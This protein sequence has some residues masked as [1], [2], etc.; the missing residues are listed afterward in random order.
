MKGIRC[1][2]ARSNRVMTA[3]LWAAARLGRWQ[4]PRRAE[5][6]RD[7]TRTKPR[8]R[9]PTGRAVP[10]GGSARAT[11]YGLRGSW[12]ERRMR[13][14]SRRS[15]RLRASASLAGVARFARR[16]CNWRI[17]VAVANVPIA[18][19]GSPRSRR[20]SVSR[21]TKR[22]AAMS[23]VEIRRLRRASARSR[24][25]LRRA[26]AAGNGMDVTFG[27]EIVSCIADIKSIYVFLI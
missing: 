25:N 8:R 5:A 16:S 24:P 12:P 6:S 22:R 27:T 21:L 4:R 26:W 17:N 11:Q 14:G 10:P 15:S 1:F 13:C 19:V 23:L 9:V 3:T 20:Q 7:H 2:P 18:T